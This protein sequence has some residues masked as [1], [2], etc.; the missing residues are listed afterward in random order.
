[1]LIKYIDDFYIET[2]FGNKEYVIVMEY[3]NGITLRELI[4]RGISD[5]EIMLVFKQILI[6]VKSLHNTI[7]EKN[8]I[9]HRDLKP[10]NILINESLKVKIIDY[11]LS[12]IIDFSTITSTGKAVGSPL[13]MSPEQIL[14]SKSI[15]KRSDIYSLGI[16]LYEMITG[17]VPYKAI[18]IQ[19]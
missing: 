16:I 15:D 9:I 8:G 11:G 17:N 2:D 19:N 4:R 3:F 1:M 6:G 13:Y 12:K 18:T 5:E 10:E 14:D 7:I